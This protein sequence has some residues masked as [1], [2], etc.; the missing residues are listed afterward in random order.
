MLF[1]LSTRYGLFFILSGGADF[2]AASCRA[3]QDYSLLHLLVKD[4]PG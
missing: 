4:M 2:Q 1:V 3:T